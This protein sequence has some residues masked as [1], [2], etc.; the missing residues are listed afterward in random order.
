M[1][2]RVYKVGSIFQQNGYFDVTVGKR[3]AKSL[4]RDRGDVIVEP[5]NSGK[6][7]SKA[8]V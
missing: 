8:L 3:D 2:E 1:S 5:K 4:Q 6:R 7:T